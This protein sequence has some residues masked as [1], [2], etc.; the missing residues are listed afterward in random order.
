M[1]RGGNPSKITAAQ[2]YLNKGDA[3]AST[4][5]PTNAIDDYKNAWKN[6]VGA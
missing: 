3:D 1:D 4:D 2:N 5:R 6:A